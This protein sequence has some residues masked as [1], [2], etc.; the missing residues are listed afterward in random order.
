[1]R[2]LFG[3]ADGYVKCEA[4]TGFKPVDSG[5]KLCNG[6]EGAGKTAVLPR[7]NVEFLPARQPDEQSVNPKYFSRMVAA[8]LLRPDGLKL[9]FVVDQHHS[10]SVGFRKSQ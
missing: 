7:P 2:G 9:V 1:M 8:F 3:G 10:D 5:S 6:G 4:V